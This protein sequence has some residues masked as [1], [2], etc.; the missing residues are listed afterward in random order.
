[1]LFSGLGLHSV[2]FLR[3]VT[4]KFKLIYHWSNIPGENS[5][6]FFLIIYL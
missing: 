6:D 1:M 2:V 3:E 4:F 5:Q